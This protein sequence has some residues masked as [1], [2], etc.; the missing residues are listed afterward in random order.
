[1]EQAHNPTTAV[2]LDRMKYV[3]VCSCGEVVDLD[4][5]PDCNERPLPCRRCEKN[6]D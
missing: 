2:D 6:R 1:M 4:L 3:I 5:C